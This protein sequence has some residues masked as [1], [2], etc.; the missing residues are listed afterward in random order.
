MRLRVFAVDSLRQPFSICYIRVAVMEV[1]GDRQ[2]DP[3]QDDGLKV[4]TVPEVLEVPPDQ[5]SQPLDE[6][7]QQLLEL[8]KQQQQQLQPT[9]PEGQQHSTQARED[10][11]IDFVTLGMFIIG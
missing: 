4:P 7:E 11:A 1:T 2:H 5:Q 3:I 8:K 9:S 6:D 10:V